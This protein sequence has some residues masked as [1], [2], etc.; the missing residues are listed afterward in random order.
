MSEKVEGG[1]NFVNRMSSMGFIPN[2]KL[3]VLQNFSHGPV[4][5]FIRDSKIALGQGEAYRL[6]GTGPCLQIKQAG[7]GLDSRVFPLRKHNSGIVPYR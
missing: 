1:R 5:V 3:A 7:P 4:L 6:I 2:M